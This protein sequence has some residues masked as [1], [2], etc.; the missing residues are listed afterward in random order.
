MVVGNVL[1]AVIGASIGNAVTNRNP[2]RH[3][4][5]STP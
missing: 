2:P 3:D 5:T 1:L 4:R